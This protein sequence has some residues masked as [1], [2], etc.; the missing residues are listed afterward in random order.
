MNLLM[1]VIKH[2]IYTYY[3]STYIGIPAVENLTAVDN[4]TSVTVSW[5]IT[6]EG[7]CEHLSYNVSLISLDDGVILRSNTTDATSHTFMEVETS[8]ELFN[9]SVTAFNV[10]ARGPSN[11]S[12]ADVHVASNG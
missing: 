3:I 6:D 8:N 7:S 9:V 2:T 11:I 12:T 4:C 10:N 5:D 1:K